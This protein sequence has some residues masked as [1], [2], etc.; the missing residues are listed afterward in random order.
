MDSVLGMKRPRPNPLEIDRISF[1]LERKRGLPP[2][3]NPIEISKPNLWESIDPRPFDFLVH[4]AGSLFK[5]EGI[6][7]GPSP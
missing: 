7:V 4:M 6:I 2:Q 1:G 3:L 5:L